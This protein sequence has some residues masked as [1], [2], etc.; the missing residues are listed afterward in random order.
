MDTLQKIP[1]I[2]KTKRSDWC[3]ALSHYSA[4]SSICN[5]CLKLKE[6]LKNYILP[7]QKVD[8]KLQNVNINKFSKSLTILNKSIIFS[9]PDMLNA[10]NFLIYFKC[11]AN[12][13][14]IFK[15]LAI[16]QRSVK[17]T[18]TVI[19]P[20]NYSK[21]ERALELILMKE[22]QRLFDPTGFIK[23]PVASAEEMLAYATDRQSEFVMLPSTFMNEYLKLINRNESFRSVSVAFYPIVS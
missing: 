4:E 18:A 2:R 14:E 7:L 23:F 22:I 5:N 1:E 17:P 16:H 9:T 10:A 8:E 3:K 15:M 6:Q 21:K 11:Q 13:S 20:Q 19:S 12:F